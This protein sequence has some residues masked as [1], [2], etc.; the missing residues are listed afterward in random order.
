MD[1]GRRHDDKQPLP[2]VRCE[3]MTCPVCNFDP[4]LRRMTDFEY[5]KTLGTFYIDGDWPDLPRETL[6]CDRCIEKQMD[7]YYQSLDS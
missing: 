6:I 4:P 5:D 1:T 3:A 7:Y 2:V